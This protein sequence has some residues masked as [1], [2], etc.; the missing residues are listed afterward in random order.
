MKKIGLLKVKDVS[1]EKLMKLKKRFEA[2]PS[3]R[4]AI[5]C[6]SYDGDIYD[7][8]IEIELDLD[9]NEVIKDILLVLLNAS[10]NE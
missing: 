5:I 3:Y 1:I 6:I 4:D 10:L 2:S 9:A 8:T 7:G